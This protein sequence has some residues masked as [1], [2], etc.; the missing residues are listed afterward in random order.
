MNIHKTH[1]TKRLTIRPITIE[2]ASFILEL[3]NSPKWIRFIGDRNVHSVSEAEV[4]IKEK[5]FPQLEKHGYTNNVI[6]RKTDNEKLGTCGLYHREGNE[7]PDIGFAFL[8]EYEGKGYAF[9]AASQLMQLGKK[10][11]GLNEL[12]AYT[13]Q[14][15]S[16]SRKLLERL[17]FKLK[18]TGK[19]PNNNEELLH[20]HRLL[21]FEI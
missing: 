21:D 18:G 17:G 16:A 19:L 1:Q 11:Y 5:A 13:L 10:D 3:M 2:D 6:V 7:D 12:S 15:N 14:E 20:Y 4:Y 8:P 9:E